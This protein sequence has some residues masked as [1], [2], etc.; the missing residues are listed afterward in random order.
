MCNKSQFNLERLGLPA[1]TPMEG[2]RTVESFGCRYV[3]PRTLLA[4]G[5]FAKGNQRTQP[6]L[7]KVPSPHSRNGG[8]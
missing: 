6:K 4:N 8:K 2:L 7:F 5:L 1:S 3:E